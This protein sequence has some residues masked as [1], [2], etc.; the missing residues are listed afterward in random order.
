MDGMASSRESELLH[1]QHILARFGELALRSEDLDEIL[2]EACH[3]VREA[4]H[5][6][7]AKVMELQED[8]TT[9]LVRAGV[10]WDPGVVGHVTVKADQGSSE[11]YAL[12]TGQPAIS[13][14]IDAEEKF[15]YP[16]FVRDA[17][18]KALV[19]VVIIGPEGHAPYGILQVDSYRP[20][21]FN[22][23]DTSFL[24]SYANLLAAAV[25]RFRAASEARWA[26]AALRESEDH[27]RAS[28]E[29][30]PQIPWTADPQGLITGFGPHL[31]VLTGLTHEAA[32]GSGWVQVPHAGDRDRMVAAWAQAIATGEPYDVEARLRLAAGGYKWH[33]MR[34]FPRRDAA[35]R[36]VQWYGTTEDVD[37]RRALEQALRQS[38]ENLEERVIERTRALEQEQR[39][40][41]TAEEKL[42]HAQKMETVGQLTGG[43][44]HDFNN[45][46]AGIV[47]SLELIQRR[48]EQ[49]RLADLQ[50]YITGAMNSANRAA[51]LT[52]RL[53]AFSRRQTLDPKLIAP[54]RLVAGIEELLRRTVGPAITLA[55]TLPAD[56]GSIL[57]DPNQ[58]ES[59]LLNLAINARDAMPG[60]G[61]LRI[62]T[63]I[64]H[65]D[66]AFTAE[67][68]LPAGDYVAL[69]VSDTGS[70][71]SPAVVKRAF[72]PFFTT[73]P[74]G[75]GTGL[76][77]SMVYGF[78][79]Q[80]NGDVLIRSKEGAG[81]SVTI[82]LP[83]QLGEAPADT[84]MPVTAQ[85]DMPRAK[86]GETVL[87]VDDEPVV[88]MLILD[89]L[90]DLGY[91]T[92]EAVDG[93][94]G[95]HQAERLM[96]S[97]NLLVTDV[98]LPGGMNGRQLADAVRL[99]NPTLKVL[100]VTG[101]AETVVAS[102]GQLEQGMDVM[103]KPFTVDAL[104]GRIRALINAE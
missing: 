87:V 71:M 38:N 88:R 61:R 99:R 37:D 86:A 64:V 45:L 12:Q 36:I 102:G 33:R 9:L 62:E 91:A 24:R 20:R 58:L 3:L 92:V 11:G 43:L 57:C 48:V 52:H 63:A 89:V 10:G 39:E 98:G 53:L 4:L 8:G 6:D 76:G 54:N 85:A 55:T 41:A 30:N 50:R 94:S 1:H 34:A 82:Y 59:A 101:Y 28:I 40:R 100:F 67:H 5:T 77:L 68:D 84:A 103:T 26:E 79:K 66:R 69:T 72:D 96:P 14:D 78:A 13:A 97:L 47:G 56:T 31:L 80:S 42:H 32:L 75:E 16:P 60:G 35:G 23:N 49:G 81:T 83:R 21:A 70:G 65:A 18:V 22:E 95:L 17:G 51:A 44:A 15:T 46:L 27:Y 25:D 29:L 19:N 93:R 74:L 7:L 90:H 104:A 73:K 2:Q